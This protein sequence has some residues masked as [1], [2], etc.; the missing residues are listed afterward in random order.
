MSRANGRHADAPVPPDWAL[1]PAAPADAEPVAEL[2]AV[3]LRPD[4]ERLGRY[5]EQRVRQRL[6]DGFEPEHTW[7]IETDGAFAGCVALRPAADAHWLEHFYLAP[8]LQG[9]GLGTAVL[10]SLL[11]RCDRE[12]VPVRLNVL[13]GSR[14]RRL[15][16]RHGFTPDSEDPVDMFMVRLPGA[17]APER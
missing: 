12:R 7:V 4:L 1:R 2:R 8:H 17:A 10:R 14:A 15:Y 13:Q 5:D 16:A 11:D 6:R 3:V 9:T